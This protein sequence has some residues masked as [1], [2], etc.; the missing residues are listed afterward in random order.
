MYIYD[1]PVVRF[2]WEYFL[3]PRLP[4]V[5]LGQSGQNAVLKVTI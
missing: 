3:K 4:R 1:K 2:V 5:G